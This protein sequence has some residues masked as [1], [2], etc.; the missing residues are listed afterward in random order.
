MC[1][2]SYLAKDPVNGTREVVD[3]A[4]EVPIPA[5]EVPI[6]ARAAA[7]QATDFSESDLPSFLPFFL[8]STERPGRE[9]KVLLLRGINLHFFSSLILTAKNKLAT[10]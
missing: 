4:R 10:L 7:E 8:S 3:L 2:V 9:E 1:E 5:R 6:Q